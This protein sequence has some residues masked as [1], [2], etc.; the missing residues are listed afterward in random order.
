MQKLA[1]KVEHEHCHGFSGRKRR[2]DSGACRRNST[3]GPRHLASAG[4]VTYLHAQVGMLSFP[5]VA[6]HDAES[7][8]APR[9]AMNLLRGSS[10]FTS[11]R[12]RIPVS[13][14]K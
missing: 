14:S 3:V 4:I 1:G 11:R 8:A 6:D 7:G 12:N 9:F 2:S 10:Y 13:S 5:G